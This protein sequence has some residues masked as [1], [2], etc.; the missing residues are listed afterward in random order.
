MAPAVPR[1][2]PDE[3]KR[4]ALQ[5]V[6]G[7][8]PAARI[9]AIAGGAVNSSFLIETTAGRFVLKL[10][11]PIG[12]VLGVDHV[13]EAH[14]QS[15]AAAAGIAPRVVHVD[16]QQRFMV[17]HYVEGKVWSA[18][19][20]DDCSKV[21][22]LGNTLRRVHA[23]TPPV[24]APLDPAAQLQNF[25]S[26][27]ARAAPEDGPQLARTI[28]DAEISLRE[29]GTAGRAPALIHS[30]PHHSNIIETAGSLILID[31][32]YAAVGDPLFD[33]ACV[34]AYYPQ[35]AS[36]TLELLE[37]AGL[38]HEATPTMLQHAVR[39]YELLNSLWERARGLASASSAG[40]RLSTPA[41]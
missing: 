7:V 14:L 2:N 25:A 3:L 20:F 39:V 36:H 11:E 21:R 40:V 22:R 13:R 31:W 1:G 27:I 5:H 4:E 9:S 10:H 38:A 18:A 17:T 33:L 41:D 28:D 15:A 19:D 37:A 24:P 23:V 12:A 32:E 26:Q 35:A 6:P 8:T 30:D 34:L 29:C 16:S